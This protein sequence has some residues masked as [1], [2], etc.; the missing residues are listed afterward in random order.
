MM[1]SRNVDSA[2]RCNSY[3]TDCPSVC[4]SVTLWYD[5]NKTTYDHT[6]V[7]KR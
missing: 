3:V 4:L 5:L 6:V 2:E 7:T 1:D